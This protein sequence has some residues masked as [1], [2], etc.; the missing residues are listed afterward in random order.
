MAPGTP[1]GNEISTVGLTI[2]S[3]DPV[4]GAVTYGGSGSLSG[5]LNR[6]GLGIVKSEYYNGFATDAAVQQAI[7]DVDTA[8]STLGSQGS[9]IK[10]QATLVEGNANTATEKINNL[11]DEIDGLIDK[12]LDEH[13]AVIAASHT[14]RL[15]C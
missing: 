12:Q 13:Q 3:Y 2:D 6:E 7:A 9:I 8:L 15:N 14:N 11:E 10:A 5:T 4:T 1:T